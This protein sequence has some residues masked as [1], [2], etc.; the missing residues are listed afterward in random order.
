MKKYKL[1]V[2]VAGP[3]TNGDVAQNVK[4]AMEVGNILMDNG[5]AVFIPHLS[6]FQHMMHPRQ[7]EDWIDHDLTWLESCDMLFRI[8][9]YSLGA[10]QEVRRA[11]ELGKPVWTDLD[12]L[13]IHFGKDNA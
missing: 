3:Y 10:D 8:D 4:K 9:G 12:R 7:Y 6:H 13:L 2:Y 1:K 11:K 5:F